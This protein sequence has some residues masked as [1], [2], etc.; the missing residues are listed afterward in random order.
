MPSGCLFCDDC[1]S[2]DHDVSNCPHACMDVCD[3]Q[4]GNVNEHVNYVSNN[5]DSRFE[6]QRG[7]WNR[8]YNNH[9]NFDN[10]NQGGGYRNQGNQGS[11]GNYNN[12]GYSSQNQNQNYGNQNQGYGN[13]NQ[14][15][16]NH[17]QGYGQNQNRGNWNNQGRGNFQ[18]NAQRGPPPGF[19]PKAQ[20][21]NSYVQSSSSSHRTNLEEIIENQTKLLNTYMTVSDKKFNEMMTH[22]KMLE[23]Q[24]SQLANALKDHA[25]PSSLPSQG[26]DPKRPVNA[27]VRRSGKVLEESLPKKG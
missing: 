18:N 10:Y 7:Q 16:G 11:R 21:D 20:N 9:G 17:N 1:G 26:L 2:Y 13:H 27:I 22:N 14:G 15:S 23:N 3:D 5:H 24:I 8:N 25:S 12:Q 6:N 4:D 19:A